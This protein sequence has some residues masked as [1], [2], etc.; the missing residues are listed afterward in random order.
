MANAH[1]LPSSTPSLLQLPPEILMTI[2]R[3]L[4]L[5]CQR[6]HSTSIYRSYNVTS[7]LS[8]SRT[9][10]YLR[11]I[12]I[13]SGL[14]CRVFP[15][16]MEAFNLDGYDSFP[17]LLQQPNL[18]SLGVNFSESSL[19]FTCGKIMKHFPSLDELS[20]SGVIHKS[21]VKGFNDSELGSAFKKFD[22]SSLILKHVSFDDSTICV[23]IRLRRENITKVCFDQC[24]LNIPCCQLP[25]YEPIRSRW[26]LPLCP[27]VRAISYSYIGVPYGKGEKGDHYLQSPLGFVALFVQQA[28]ELE[29]LEMSYGF[30]PRL[31]EDRRLV[32]IDTDQG[33]DEMYQ[34]ANWAYETCRRIMLDFVREN[35]NSSLLSYT[36]HESLTGPFMEDTYWWQGYGGF[37][38][39]DT[40][41]KIKLLSFRCPDLRSLTAFDGIDDC[42]V[43]Y[44]HRSVN[45][46]TLE[47]RKRK[48]CH[49]LWQHVRFSLS[50]ICLRCSRFQ[51][52]TH[53]LINATA[54]SSRL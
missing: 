30:R 40:F 7:L 13:A 35:V 14:F 21:M 52:C 38:G 54:F 28:F 1:F 32:G 15:R 51:S 46:T 31:F 34:N 53:T 36:E 19:W 6:Y 25:Y 12:C 50:K 5:R 44:Q 49:S 16:N 27:N 45:W 42:T 17:Y 41:D 11:S 33:Y 26:E 8:L 24:E 10:S 23:L 2:A 37:L 20:L 47:E 29:H 3:F 22:G 18:S 4:V 43:G 39:H 9:H 48:Q